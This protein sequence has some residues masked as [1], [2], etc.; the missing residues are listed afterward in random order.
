MFSILNDYQGLRINCA[1]VLLMQLSIKIGSRNKV[2]IEKHVTIGVSNVTL[3]IIARSYICCHSDMDED[4]TST[5]TLSVFRNLLET[6]LTRQ[7]YE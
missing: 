4:A 2:S 1:Y 6:H 5:P 7:S 3:I